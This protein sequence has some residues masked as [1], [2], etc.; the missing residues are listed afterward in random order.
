MLG[1]NPIGAW[2]ALYLRFLNHTLLDT[3]TLGRSP[4]N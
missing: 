2:V 3:N 1:N 4:L